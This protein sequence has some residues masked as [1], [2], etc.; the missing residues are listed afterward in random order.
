M[1][2]VSGHR[3]CSSGA[4][5]VDAGSAA[6]ANAGAARQGQG[7]LCRPWGMSSRSVTVLQI[8]IRRSSDA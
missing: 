6:A 8:R 5:Q 3:S 7:H 1:M 2:C 4:D